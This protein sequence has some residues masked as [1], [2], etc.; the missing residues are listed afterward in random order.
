MYAE[1]K[2]RVL[3]CALAIKEERLV[4]MSGGNVSMRLSDGNI[5]VTPSGMLYT[6][7][8]PDDVVLVD[9]GGKVVEGTRKPSSDLPA[10][11]YIFEKMPQV[12]A[13]IHTHQPYATAIG[14]VRG[15]LPATLVTLIDANRAAVPVA[16]WAASSNLG[17]G[18]VTVE[19]ATDALAVILKH[20]GI[21]AFGSTL[22]EALYS[23]V[24]LEEGAKTYLLAAAIGEVPELGS[25]EIA[26][27]S[28]GWQNYGQ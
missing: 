5:L 6:D 15:S 10:L 27:E 8:T 9:P 28:A 4:S 3:E 12:N 11:L 22:D 23:A 13:I 24:Y 19:H 14:L 20:H 2:K 25:A 1:E 21:I 17:M 16:P 18:V 7:M 26:E